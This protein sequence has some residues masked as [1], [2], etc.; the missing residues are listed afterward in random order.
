MKT[1]QETIQKLAFIRANAVF[2]GDPFPRVEG[3]QTVAWIY[4]KTVEEVRADIEV[5]MPAAERKV[6]YG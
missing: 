6:M 2:A 1:Y 3:I 4:E 5:E